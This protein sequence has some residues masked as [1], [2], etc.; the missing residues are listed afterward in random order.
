MRRLLELGYGIYAACALVAV[1]LAFAP[2][3]LLLP[4]LR[5][6]RDAGRWAVRLAMALA[7]VP[8]RV[9]GLQRL[10]DGPCIVVSNHASYLDGPL[11]TAALPGRFTFVV[12]HGAADWP[13][14]GRIIRRMGVSFVNRSAARSGAAQTRALIRRLEQGES[15]VIFAEGTFA[16]TPG[17]L[18]FRKGAFLMAVHAR[19]PVVPAVIRGSRRIFGE[20]QRLLRP[21]R[22]DI[23]VFA[24]LQPGGDHRHAVDAL[25]DESRRVVL[26]HCG[27]PDVGG[28]GADD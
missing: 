18:P 23:E 17:L 14:A 7:L 8:V 10:P 11:M 1:A 16:G 9:R 6:R 2:L 25:R 27:E 20:G 21:G 12:Q 22:I 3:V 4:T 19:V 26:E 5:L 13:L 15:L 28:R 24:P